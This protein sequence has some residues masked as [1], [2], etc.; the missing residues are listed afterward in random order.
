MSTRVHTKV[1]ALHQELVDAKKRF[2]HLLEN[3]DM[4][5]QVCQPIFHERDF[6]KSVVASLYYLVLNN[7]MV[8]FEDSAD[9]IQQPCALKPVF[10]YKLTGVVRYFNASPNTACLMIKRLRDQC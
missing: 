2:N 9:I 6:T 8:F 7:E 1:K 3:S 4:L 5:E 10:K